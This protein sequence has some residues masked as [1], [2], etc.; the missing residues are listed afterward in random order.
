MRVPVQFICFSC[1]LFSVT[2][3]QGQE[4]TCELKSTTFGVKKINPEGKTIFRAGESVEITCTEKYWI[5][6][7]KETIN[8]F[9]CRENGEWDYEPVCADIRC[10]VPHDQHVSSPGYYFWGDLKLGVKKD[11]Y[12]M[13]GY[14]QMS[15][16]ATCTRD[17]W[18]PKPLCRAKQRSCRDIS[19][20]NGFT[21]SN[22]EEIIYSCNP[23]YK[24]FTGGNWWDSVTC[25]KGSWS[26]E[27]RCIR[28]EECGAF[29]SVH[30]GKLKQSLHDR[31]PAEV[32][33]DPGF[34]STQRFITCVR[35]TWEK[36]VC[37]VGVSCNI[38]PK[39]EYAF[40]TSKPEELYAHGS[41]VTYKCRRSFLMKGE[42]TVFCRN[43]TWDETPTCEEATC[44][45]NTTVE[46]LKIMRVPNI[47]GSVKPGHKLRF[48]CNGQWLILKGQREIT[49]QPNGEWSSPFPK[50][51][52]VMC[53]ANLTINMRSDEQPAPE[54]SIRPGHTITLSCVGKGSELQGQ[55]KITCLP[56]GEWNV[57]FPKCV[58]GKCGP[59]PQVD[60]ADTTEMTKPEY[61][62]GER[63]EYI[64]FNKYTLVQDHPYSK[65]LTCEHGEWRGNIKCFKPCSVTVEEMDKRGIELR[66]GPL[67]KIFSPHEDRISFACQR[68]KDLTDSSISLIQYCNDGVMHLPECV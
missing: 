40:I 11:Y 60:F 2:V 37:E 9:T 24:P 31:G 34:I 15:A 26:E 46:D 38:P 61:N 64:C 56:N 32:E 48:S 36:P 12:C 54:V 6:Q 20:E 13:S 4:V 17:G 45:L 58:G 16:V 49:C 39:V 41:S 35:G 25:S 22:D 68:G 21:Q 10:E 18:T 5:F 27:P 47:E 65:Y 66:W 62:S 19:V 67:E 3:V 28:E 50:C 29:P 8:S 33:C 42:N 51:E 1:F 30:H 57:P 59:P 63:V 44:S 55:S 14:D 43:G 53:V 52:E 23:G 7:T